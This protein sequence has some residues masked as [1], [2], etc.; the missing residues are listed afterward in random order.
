MTTQ[1]MASYLDQKANLMDDWAEE[2]ISGGWSTHQVQAQRD[3]ANEFRR[4]AA[5]LRLP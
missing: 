2:S 3:L 1:E 4:K 5:Q